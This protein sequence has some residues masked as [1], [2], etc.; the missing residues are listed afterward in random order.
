MAVA[1]MSFC[2]GCY[3]RMTTSS[4]I[5]EDDAEQAEVVDQPADAGTSVMST[6]ENKPMSPPDASPPTEYISNEAILAL[7]PDQSYRQAG[8]RR[9]NES[10]FPSIVAPGKDIVLWVTADA[11]AAYAAVSTERPGS[12][13]HVPTGTTIVREVFNAGKLET[14][15]VMKKLEPGAFALG[16]DWFYLATDAEGQV[17]TDAASGAPS[18]GL[19]ENCG[20][21][22]LRRS[23]D[24]YLFGIPPGYLDER[25]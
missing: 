9:L 22:H 8:F 6:S 16:G 25:E 13:V 20:T 3:A 7:L 2:A 11:Y 24:D 4:T 23:R 18:I 12:G 17:R 5:S 21:C 15:T 1:L 10:P 19:S 14:I